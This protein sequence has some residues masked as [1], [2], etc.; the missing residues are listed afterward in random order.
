MITISLTYVLLFPAVLP[1][2]IL[3]DHEITCKPSVISYDVTLKGGLNAGNFTPTGTVDGMETCVH[4]CCESATCD[5]AFM[6]KDSC[7]SV[8]C[9]SE[10]L[11]EEIPAP[12]SA[13]YPRLS[14]VRKESKKRDKGKSSFKLSN[15]KSAMLVGFLL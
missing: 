12:S 1:Q 9:S 8:G 6:L 14:F 3:I 10:E 5:V 2:E 11:C 7:Y 15:G 4:M 13:Y